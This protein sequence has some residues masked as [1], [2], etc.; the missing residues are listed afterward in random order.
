MKTDIP[1]WRTILNGA[2]CIAAIRL[3]VLCYSLQKGTHS[4]CDCTHPNMLCLIIWTCSR[5]VQWQKWLKLAIAQ[6]CS[7][8][9]LLTLNIKLEQSAWVWWMRVG[10]YSL[11]WQCCPHF[12]LK[13]HTDYSGF[14]EQ[15]KPLQPICLAAEFKLES[16][17]SLCLSSGNHSLGW[18]DRQAHC[19]QHKH[20]EV[21][22]LQQ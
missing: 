18:S 22:S 2:S 6:S 13:L 9:P 10:I 1:W 20:R 21:P 16:K 4:L 15:R 19:P 14:P 17:L 12:C 5:P 11:L 7:D 8:F 3:C